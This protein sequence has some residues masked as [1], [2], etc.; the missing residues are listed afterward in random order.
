MLNILNSVPVKMY[1]FF[2]YYSF[3]LW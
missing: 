3:S 2:N 1:R